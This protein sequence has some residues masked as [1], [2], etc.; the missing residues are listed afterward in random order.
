MLRQM[1]RLQRDRKK[2]LSSVK[3]LPIDL[4]PDWKSCADVNEN[5]SRVDIDFF[6]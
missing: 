1:A 2:E 3:S 4:Y 6:F 5:V